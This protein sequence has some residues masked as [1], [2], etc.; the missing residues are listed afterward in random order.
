MA[1]LFYEQFAFCLMSITCT[2]RWPHDLYF[3]TPHWRIVHCYVYICTGGQG[4]QDACNRGHLQ[5][6]STS[7]REGKPNQSCKNS[8]LLTAKKSKNKLLYFFSPWWDWIFYAEHAWTESKEHH[9]AGGNWG[10]LVQSFQVSE[11]LRTVSVSPAAFSRGQPSIPA[12]CPHTPAAEWSWGEMSQKAVPTQTV[13]AAGF[14]WLKFTNIVWFRAISTRRK[15]RFWM[16]WATQNVAFLSSVLH[17]MRD[18]DR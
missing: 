11:T 9:M 16:N 7:D 14:W 4:V 8:Q 17:F 10:W 15:G 12:P 3:S 13:L 6:K 18:W 5:Y 1:C 2:G